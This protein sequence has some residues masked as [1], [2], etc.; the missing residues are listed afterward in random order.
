[1]SDLLQKPT[2]ISMPDLKMPSDS[3]LLHTLL[4]NMPDTIYFKDLKSRFVRVNR[5]WLDKIGAKTEDAVLGKT[6]FDF[7][8]PEHARQAF[9]D[10][11][12]IIATGQPMVGIEEKE[13]WLDRPDTWVSTTKMP[14]RNK[15]G[16]T[17]GTFGL[18]RDITEIKNY[19]D[20]LQ[21]AKDELEDRVKERTAEL[22]E[23]K[24]RLEQNLEQLSFLNVT[25]YELVQ[26]VDME[27]LFT[28]IGTAFSARFP[29][30]QVS[31]CYKKKGAFSCVYATSY[32][33]SPEAKTLSEIALQPFLEKELL[34]QVFIDDWRQT[35]HLNLEWP[36]EVAENPI[37]S[38][39]RSLPTR[40]RLQSCSSLCRRTVKRCSVGNRPS[41]LPLRLMRLCAFPM[42]F[43]TRNS[44]A[45]PGWKG[46]SRRPA[47][48][49]RA[50]L[51][52]SCLSSR[53]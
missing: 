8:T 33:N 7:F 50:L 26:I 5:F 19:R 41:S 3:E 46:S 23:A 34:S 15:K 52:R 39:F 29:V 53:T 18:S 6:D 45:K 49:S 40:K 20:A 31:I 1:M 24:F 28:V 36:K 47:T 22:I 38:P 42:R 4:D 48:Y 11:Q 35:S 30:A 51:R 21:A 17:I 9:N 27:Q 37:G 10:E 25:S 16:E 14:F 43:I 44:R 32:L 13:T 12:N 2:G